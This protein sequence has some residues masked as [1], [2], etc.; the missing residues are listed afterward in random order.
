MSDTYGVLLVDDQFRI[1]QEIRDALKERK[2]LFVKSSPKHPLT[3]D[4]RAAI[5]GLIGV[6]FP[7]ASWDKRFFRDVLHPALEAGMIGERSAPQLWRI[8]IRYRRQVRIPNPEYSRLLKVASELS[9][10]DY[11]KQQ[12]ALNAQAKIDEMKRKYAE[13]MEK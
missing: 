4:E 8:F 9:A 2:H 12:A 13:A 1:G 6:T 11:R 5:R 3:D 10:P 7:V